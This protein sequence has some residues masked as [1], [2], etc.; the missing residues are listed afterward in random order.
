MAAAPA[1]THSARGPE[2]IDS[3]A[4]FE[5]LVSANPELARLAVGVGDV[6]LQGLPYGEQEFAD[7]RGVVDGLL[8]TNGD[9][10][11]RSAIVREPQLENDEQYSRALQ[12]WRSLNWA[13]RTNP[14]AEAAANRRRRLLR[15]GIFLDAYNQER[16]ETGSL[17]VPA[18]TSRTATAPTTAAA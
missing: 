14:E 1:F 4:R 6:A 2:Q 17:G 12:D 13:S 18:Q 5:D 7:A 10:M 11:L 3:I 9:L 8:A 15:L 16:T